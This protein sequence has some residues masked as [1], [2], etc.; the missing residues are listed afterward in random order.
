MRK[1]GGDVQPGFL[2]GTWMKRSK[3]LDADALKLSDGYRPVLRAKVRRVL[4]Q[5][6][7]AIRRDLVRDPG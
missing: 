3:I 6:I 1:R 7:A 2:A 5:E 4:R